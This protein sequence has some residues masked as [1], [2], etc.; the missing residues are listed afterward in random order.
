MFPA[1]CV[2]DAEIYPRSDDIT[3]PHHTL[4]DSRFANPVKQCPT[5]RKILLTVAGVVLTVGRLLAFVA[6]GKE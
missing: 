1:S 5:S 6:D 4:V 3:F 2:S